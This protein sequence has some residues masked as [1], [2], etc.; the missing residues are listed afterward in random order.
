L[1]AEQARMA[2]EHI[3]TKEKRRAIHKGHC[4]AL[5]RHQ[6]TRSTSLIES[7]ASQVQCN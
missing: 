2:T 6:A 3:A 7:R 1:Q 4:W 5:D